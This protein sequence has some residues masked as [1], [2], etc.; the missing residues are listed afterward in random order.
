[1]WLTINIILIIVGAYGIYHAYEIDKPENAK[2]LVIAFFS[3]V[4]I[5]VGIIGLI[6]KFFTQG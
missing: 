5:I 3:A 1:M 2:V 4:S 6:I